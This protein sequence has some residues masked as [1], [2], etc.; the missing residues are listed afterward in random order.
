M[1][2]ASYAVE[3]LSEWAVARTRL[4]DRS[5]DLLDRL[6][7][8]RLGAGEAQNLLKD[9]LA[10]AGVLTETMDGVE[11][12]GSPVRLLI[13]RGDATTRTA[14]RRMIKQGKHPIDGPDLLIDVLDAEN[15]DVLQELLDAGWNPNQVSARGEVPLLFAIDRK[16]PDVV[17]ILLRAGADSNAH[18][19]RGTAI[20]HLINGDVYHPRVGRPEAKI[21]WALVEAGLCIGQADIENLESRATIKGLDGV[22]NILREYSP[23]ERSVAPTDPDTT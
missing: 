19:A 9:E 8:G 21:A 6:I 15:I 23:S 20:D 2:P 16:N 7:D 17:R 18:D 5:I 14:I 10:W 22:A 3:R 1:K 12:P 4:A 13:D 11:V